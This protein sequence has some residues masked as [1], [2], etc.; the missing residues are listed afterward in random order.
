MTII[1]YDGKTGMLYADSGVVTNYR[2][3]CETKSANGNKIWTSKCNRIVFTTTGFSQNS[4]SRKVIED[5]FI[6]RLDIYY[7][8]GDTSVFKVT[9]DD[10]KKL[11]LGSQ[12]IIAVTKDM[13]YVYAADA[14]DPGS[15]IL[16]EDLDIV[17]GYGAFYT[18]AYA[19]VVLGD[20]ME[21]GMEHAVMHDSNSALPIV[22][23][24]T[25][26]LNAWQET[27]E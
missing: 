21:R 17:I 19:V 10:G 8:T 26:L 6:S 12:R 3:Y 13:L 7:K 2:G 11:G 27:V 9:T 1:A 23:F 18:Y 25:K 20:S 14:D 24:N 15:E 22:S 5:F 4:I 16:I